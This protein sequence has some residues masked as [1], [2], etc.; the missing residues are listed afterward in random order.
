MAHRI[1]ERLVRE[2]DE[3]LATLEALSEHVKDYS[4]AKTTATNGGV[5]RMRRS[6]IQTIQRRW[7]E[8]LCLASSAIQPQAPDV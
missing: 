3:A 1:L 4:E 7:R 8:I 6:R 5:D 2:C